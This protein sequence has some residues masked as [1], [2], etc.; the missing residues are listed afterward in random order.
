MVL[1]RCQV[2]L[3]HHLGCKSPS[4]HRSLAMLLNKVLLWTTLRLSRHLGDV[5]LTNQF[6]IFGSGGF[7]CENFD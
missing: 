1:R 3:V 7:V 4:E 2:Q 5:V 6:S